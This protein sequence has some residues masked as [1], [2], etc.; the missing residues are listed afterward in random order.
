MGEPQ[1]STRVKNSFGFAAKPGV[2]AER[3]EGMSGDSASEQRAWLFIDSWAGRGRHCVYVVGETP[4]C[5]RIRS[6]E[7]I[8]MAGRRWLEIG[9][10]A[11]VPKH[12]IVRFVM[13]T[14]SR[15]ELSDLAR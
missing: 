2:P 13:K 6:D 12:A 4:K 11:L 15:H 9:A 10:T 8:K 7:R 1:L 5:F 14:R 3:T